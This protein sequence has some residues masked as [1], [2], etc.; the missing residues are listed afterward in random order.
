MGLSSP[1]SNVVTFSRPISPL[2]PSPLGNFAITPL[3]ALNSLLN[4]M[5]R[6][7][8]ALSLVMLDWTDM[9]TALYSERRRAGST[10]ICPC[11]Q[12]SPLPFCLLDICLPPMSSGIDNPAWWLPCHLWCWKLDSCWSLQGPGLP[13]HWQQRKTLL[14][15]GRRN[16][17]LFDV[18]VI[19]DWRRVRSDGCTLR[20]KLL[21]RNKLNANPLEDDGRPRRS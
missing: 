8:L 10:M 6:S 1:R 20:E 2:I 18:L 19:I 7:V 9:L 16:A 11:H 3:M 4:W 13:R 5:K 17:Y 12:R 21:L 15:R 14:N